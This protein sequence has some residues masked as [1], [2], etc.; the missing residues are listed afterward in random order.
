MLPFLTLLFFYQA[1]G[2]EAKANGRPR[3]LIPLSLRSGITSSGRRRARSNITPRKA[4]LNPHGHILRQDGFEL[5]DILTGNAD[6]SPKGGGEEVR[7]QQ[8]EKRLRGL[9]DSG[10]FAV[11][12]GDEDGFGAQGV[13]FGV[14]GALGEDGHLVL[15]EFVGYGL[16]AVFEREGG[17]QF[18]LDDRV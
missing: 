3:Y 12:G 9:L 4:L 16:G 8:I 2:R 11:K 17:G 6:R 18:A 13:E 7:L 1:H 14:H 5:V 15:R 10:I